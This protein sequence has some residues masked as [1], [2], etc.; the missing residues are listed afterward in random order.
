MRYFAYENWRAHGH[1]T[2]VHRADC[3]FCNDGKGMAGGT[4]ADNGLWIDLGEFDQS[5]D[6]I[7]AAQSQIREGSIRPCAKC[8]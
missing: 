4:R 5:G 6:A 3:V 8:C 2:K 7:A 1:I